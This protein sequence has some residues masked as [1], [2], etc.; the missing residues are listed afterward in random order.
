M[1]LADP[2][3]MSELLNNKNITAVFKH[4]S[5][6]CSLTSLLFSLSFSKQR[7]SFEGNYK[8]QTSFQGDVFSRSWMSAWKEN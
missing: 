3:S 4:V 7:D 5:A 6:L 8:V 1:R 2:K